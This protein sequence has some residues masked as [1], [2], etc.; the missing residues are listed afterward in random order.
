MVCAFGMNGKILFKDVRLMPSEGSRN[1]LVSWRDGFHCKD[2]YEQCVFEDCQVG[3]LGDDVFN[4]ATNYHRVFEAV[5]DTKFVLYSCGKGDTEITLNPG[6]TIGII[7]MEEGYSLGRATVVSAVYDNGCPGKLT[8]C[9]DKPIKNAK[10]DHIVEL[11]FNSTNPDGFLVKNCD[12][13]GSIRIK[14]PATFEN[15]RIKT[16]IVYI[17]NEQYW[18]GPLPTNIHLRNCE[19]I[20][21]YPGQAWLETPTIPSNEELDSYYPDK[22]L[23]VFVNACSEKQLMGTKLKTED[24]SI[25]NCKIT[26]I[27]ETNGN[28]VKII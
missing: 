27:V 19:I 18:E 4:L 9:V 24:I 21:T 12:L 16:S 10:K 26:G 22:N 2:H 23:A 20:S 13:V 8:V 3:M 28:D 25:E 11:I 15:C 6:D 1:K 14:A 5:S 7:D 17:S